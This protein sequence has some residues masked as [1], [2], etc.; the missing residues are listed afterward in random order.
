MYSILVPGQLPGQDHPAG[1]QVGAPL[2]PVQ[3]VDGQLGG[4]MDGQV[5]DRLAQHAHHAQVLDDHRVHADGAGVGGNF[6]G[7]GQLPVGEQGV[8]GQV[9]LAP[10]QVAIRN[11][12][13]S[14][15]SREVFRVAA[16]VEISISKIDRVRSVLNGGGDRLHGAGRG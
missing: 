10:P 8:Q 6:G 9:D 2:H 4:G 1:P 3:G 16:G 12:R 14:L 11:R 5:G 15:L 7:P 13:R